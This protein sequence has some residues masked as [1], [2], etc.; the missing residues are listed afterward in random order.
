MIPVDIIKISETWRTGYRR[1]YGRKR[2]RRGGLLVRLR[3]LQYQACC[4]QTCNLPLF[5]LTF[6]TCHSLFVWF[7][8]VYKKK[9]SIIIPVP[10]KTTATCM[11]DFRLVA[12]TSVIMK[13]FEQLV[14]TS[15]TTY[16]SP[17]IRYNLHTDQTELWMM[18]YPWLYILCSNI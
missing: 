13:C 2:G 9:K 6:L 10:K 12:L 8:I 5:S 14:N 4:W 18:L 17:L 11:N 3:G 16:L 15:T 1:R 7:Q